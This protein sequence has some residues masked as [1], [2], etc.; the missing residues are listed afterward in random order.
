MS[1]SPAPFAI[2]IVPGGQGTEYGLTVPTISDPEQVPEWIQAR[3]DEGADYVK[4]IYEHGTVIAHPVL[5]LGAWRL[6]APPRPR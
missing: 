3:R 2:A 4:V 1:E 5:E 6:V